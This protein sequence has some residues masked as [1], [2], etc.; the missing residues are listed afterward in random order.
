MEVQRDQQREES[1]GNMEKDCIE[2]RG[3]EMVRNCSPSQQDYVE[4]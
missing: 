3:K 1:V 2:Q 4:Q